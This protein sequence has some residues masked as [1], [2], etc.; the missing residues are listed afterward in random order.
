[1]MPC[2]LVDVYWNFRETYCHCIQSWRANRPRKQQAEWNFAF[3]LL[4][5]IL[6]L[7][8]HA[9]RKWC[10]IEN[11]LQFHHK[12]VRLQCGWILMVFNNAIQLLMLY[13]SQ[14]Y[15]KMIINV[16]WV[17][18]CRKVVMVISR[19]YPGIW[20]DTVKETM[21]NLSQHSWKS[22][23]DSSGYLCTWPFNPSVLL[24]V[25]LRFVWVGSLLL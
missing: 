12:E 25:V 2:S 24:Y 3:K 18:I 15:W 14:W 9:Q 13:S 7:S 8:Y 21:K 19:Y 16:N 11:C 1:M 20:Q 10:S 5:F 4:S 22:S 23:W 6:M 17:R